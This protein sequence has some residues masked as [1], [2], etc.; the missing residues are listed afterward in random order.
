MSTVVKKKNVV[1]LDLL[2]LEYPQLVQVL[3]SYITRHE[4]HD[5]FQETDQD[6]KEVAEFMY[7]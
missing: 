1:S 5:Q 6:G 7:H 4:S 3:L 2:F